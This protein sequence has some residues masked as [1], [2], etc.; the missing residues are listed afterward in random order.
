MNTKNSSVDEATYYNGEKWDLMKVTTPRCTCGHHE[1]MHC[2]VY[3]ARCCMCACEGYEEK[4]GR[5]RK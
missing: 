1:T 5:G 4:R 2:N 3:T